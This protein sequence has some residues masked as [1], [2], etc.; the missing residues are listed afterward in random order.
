M[1]RKGTPPCDCGCGRPR[2][3]RSAYAS[4]ACRARAWK[5][6]HNYGPQKPRKSRTN[7][8]PKRSGRQISY[9]KAVEVLA[10]HLA[11][12]EFHWC[13]S[14]DEW[15]AVAER[16]LADALPERQRARLGA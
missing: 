2:E 14:D 16:W 3:G 6:R 7:G 5:A 12:E 10:A 4:D 1:Q 13:E 11:A 8:N 9:R 15:Y